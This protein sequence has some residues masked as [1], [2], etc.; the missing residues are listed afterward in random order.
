MSLAG[1]EILLGPHAATSFAL[2]FHELATNAAK[3]GPF[4]DNSGRLDISWQMEASSLNVEWKETVAKSEITAPTGE[5]FGTK[6]A[7]TSATH[8]LGGSINYAWL[9]GGV[10]IKLTAATDRLGT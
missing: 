4:R 7:R 10:T 3:Y 5:G 1:P 8:Q 6:L 9:P 2:I